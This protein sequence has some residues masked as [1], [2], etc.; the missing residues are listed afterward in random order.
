MRSGELP[1]EPGQRGRDRTSRSFSN[2]FKVP[3]QNSSNCHGTSL[4][5]VLET[6]VVDATSGENHVG[7]GGQDLLDS[8]LGDIGFST[9]KG[10]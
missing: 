5:K 3:F 6:H 1:E 8:F 2:A 9:K 7:T 10:V 4:H